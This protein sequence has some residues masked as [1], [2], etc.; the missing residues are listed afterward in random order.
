MLSRAEHTPH[1][2]FHIKGPIW[3]Q[4]N[5]AQVINQDNIKG[6]CRWQFQNAWIVL[7]QMTGD[8]MI[9]LIEF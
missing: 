8:Y 9:M 1:K 4:K 6:I 5:V 3:Q 7:I 2:A